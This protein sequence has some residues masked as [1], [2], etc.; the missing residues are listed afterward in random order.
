MNFNN[1]SLLERH[2]KNLEL[3]QVK[4]ITIVV[5]YQNDLIVE[6]LKSLNCPQ[7]NVVFNSEYELGSIVSVFRGLKSASAKEDILLMD[8]DVLYDEKILNLMIKNKESC[9][10]YDAEFEDDDEPVKVCIEKTK[11][12]NLVRGSFPDKNSL[13]SVSQLAFLK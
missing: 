2:I 3:N 8:G 6:K 9:L 13:Q 5:G 7:I 11:S 1:K 4:N 12:K 10:A